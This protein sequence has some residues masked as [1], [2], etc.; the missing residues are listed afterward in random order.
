MENKDPPFVLSVDLPP[1]SLSESVPSSQFCGPAQ[2]LPHPEPYALD[3]KADYSR[4]PDVSSVCSNSSLA[5]FNSKDRK[6]TLTFPVLPHIRRGLG[7]PGTNAS[8]LVLQMEHERE[9]GNLNHCLKLAQEREDLEKEL[10]R[11]TLERRSTRQQHFGSERKE[12]GDSEL[13]WEYKSRTLP[14]RYLQG[15]KQRS[16]VSSS[17]IFPSAI[18]W[19]S[20]A[21]DL[22]CAN[23]ATSHNEPPAMSSTIGPR[24]HCG[25]A[26]RASAG[27][28]TLPHQSSKKDKKVEAAPKGCDNS[29]Q[30]ALTEMEMDDSCSEKR[31]SLSPLSSSSNKHAER[32][33]SAH[34]SRAEVLFPGAPDK[35]VSV[36]MS[37]DEPELEDRMIAP[38]RLML[39]NRIASHL[40]PSHSPSKESWYE[41]MRSIASFNQSDSAAASVNSTPLDSRREPSR[42]RG[43]GIWNPVL[44]SQSLDLR[45]QREAEFLAPDAWI[46]SFSQENCSLL[47]SDRLGSSS[48][49]IM[50]PSRTISKSPPSSQH[51][52]SAEESSERLLLKNN[53]SLNS[54]SQIKECGLQGALTG[55]QRS[56]EMTKN[57]STC[58]LEAN[59]LDALEIEAGRFEMGPQS[60]SY[61]SYASSGR[62]SMG[63]AN[64]RLFI[65][66]LPP[67]LTGSPQTIEEIRE[68]TDNQAPHRYLCRRSQY[69]KFIYSFATSKM[70][71]NTCS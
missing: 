3:A 36:E 22:T 67:S 15:Q 64:G 60:G 33:N 23:R 13:L 45:G 25:E 29:P 34:S 21:P 19:K 69:R 66:H 12:R 4:F 71:I 28:W 44:R 20:T 37:V 65:C 38:S 24:L 40:Q 62:G 43:S 49:E 56:A 48:L 42:V 9:T 39:H 26:G 2:H 30:S 58:V 55:R 63:P 46:N 51:S 52:L 5:T 32:A 70:V 57:V 7:Q 1:G 16:A 17:D 11:Y 6:P 41:D 27:R 50:L 8:A 54:G 31:S 35:K 61:S 68:R 53:V 10:Q 14:H 47:S 18:G 59:H